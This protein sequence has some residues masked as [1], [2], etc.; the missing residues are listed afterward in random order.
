MIRNPFRFG[1]VVDGEFFTDRKKEISKIRSF[2]EGENHMVLISPRRYG[3]TSLIRKVLNET[4]RRYLYLDLQIVLSVDDFA[5]QLLKRIY[6]LFPIQKIKG[7]MKSF[8]IIPSLIMNPVTGETEISF[9]SGSDGHISTEDVLNLLDKLGSSKNKTIVVL[10]EFQDIFRIESGLDRFL[11]SVMQNQ[12]NINYI[13]MGS[14]ESMIRDIFEK[15]N[16]PFYRFGSLMTLGKIPAPEFTKFL[17]E[18]FNPVT[19]NFRKLTAGILSITD[20]HPFYTQQLAFTVWEIINSTGYSEDIISEASEEI[21]QSHDNDYERI[22]NSLNRTDMA[23]LTGM[24]LSDLSPLSD[25]FIKEYDLG[26]PSTIFSALRRLTAKGFL[27]RLKKGYVIDDPF[28]KL[29]IIKRR[30]VE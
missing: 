12:K 7:F 8:R 29:W 14:S 11:R 6:N 16:S 25:S 20:H 28:F 13:L 15:K 5:A 22:W 19:G 17:E 24:C 3:K 26:A 9:R 1:T 2:I 21:V 10:D 18:R 4:R 27:A 23:V 30:K